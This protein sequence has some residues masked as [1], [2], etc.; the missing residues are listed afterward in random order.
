MGDQQN[1][2]VMHQVQAELANA[3]AQE[4]FT[5]RSGDARSTLRET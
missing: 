2:A 1:E 4:F 5:V 3:Y